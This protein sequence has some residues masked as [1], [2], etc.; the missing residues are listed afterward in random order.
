M[1]MMFNNPLGNVFFIETI[2]EYLNKVVQ[3]WN[4]QK[5]AFG[6]K[7]TFTFLTKFL[8]NVLDELIELVEVAIPNGPD[9]KATVMSAITKIYDYVIAQIMPF[10]L[11][12]F[13]GVIK[14]FV[15]NTIISAA[16]D[17]IVDHYKNSIWNKDEPVVE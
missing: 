3:I 16:I 4:E 14:S 12:P 10:W 13:S 1:M 8:F 17:F 15:L 7:V 6:G 9:K 5:A 11:K 2:Q